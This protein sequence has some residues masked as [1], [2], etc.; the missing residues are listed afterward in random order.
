MDTIGKRIEFIF[1]QSGYTKVR[2]SKAIGISDSGLNK[3]MGGVNPRYDTIMSIL[4]AFPETDLE[5]LITGDKSEG[6]NH[7]QTKVGEQQLKYGN[8]LINDIG[9]RQE[10]KKIKERLDRL[11]EENNIK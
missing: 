3:I 8:N 11:E 10:L 7:Y 4:K 5:W 6:I 9:L 2:F 1:R